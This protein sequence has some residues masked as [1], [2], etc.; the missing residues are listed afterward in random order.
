MRYWVKLLM[1]EGMEEME[2]GITVEEMMAEVE[3][4]V[5]VTRSM[6]AQTCN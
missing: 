2:E 3:T 6:I 1:G 5:E 4:G